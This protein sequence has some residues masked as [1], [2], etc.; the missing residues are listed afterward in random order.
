MAAGW[1][2]RGTERQS[3]FSRQKK[4]KKKKKSLFGTGAINP[5]KALSHG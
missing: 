3:D 1:M 4:K 2:E 5:A